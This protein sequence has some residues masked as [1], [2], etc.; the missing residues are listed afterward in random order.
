MRRNKEKV[1]DVTEKTLDMAL[2]KAEKYVASGNDVH[3][4]TDEKGKSN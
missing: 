4:T 1:F 2:D 3:I